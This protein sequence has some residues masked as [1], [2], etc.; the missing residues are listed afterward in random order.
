MY[1]NNETLCSEHYEVEKEIVE[2]VED[3]KHL[4][5]SKKEKRARRFANELLGKTRSKQI[6]LSLTKL[7]RN[8]RMNERPLLNYF[9]FYFL[10]R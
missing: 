1:L 3:T 7:V 6:S 2:E 9:S 10:A 5:L 8:H 4:D